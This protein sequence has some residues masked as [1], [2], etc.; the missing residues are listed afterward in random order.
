M[1]SP[2]L[3]EYD[4]VDFQVS[5]PFSLLASAGKKLSNFISK[6]QNKLFC[7]SGETRKFSINWQSW[8]WQKFLG[9]LFKIFREK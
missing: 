4:Q 3:S 8:S 1:G 6:E 7:R 9:H 5:S 2:L